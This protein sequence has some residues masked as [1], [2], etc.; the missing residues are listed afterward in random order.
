MFPWSS[1]FIIP[2]CLL[3]LTKRWETICVDWLPLLVLSCETIVLVLG[4]INIIFLVEGIRRSRNKTT[5]LQTIRDTDLPTVLIIV[6]TCGE[7][8]IVLKRT[9]DALLNLDYPEEKLTVVITDDCNDDDLELQVLEYAKIHYKRR[10]F[11]KGHAKAGN[12]NDTLFAIENKD[13]KYKGEL[14]LIL[15]CDMAP[16]P[17]MLKTLVSYLYKDGQLHYGFVQSPQHFENIQGFD[18]LGQHYYFFYQ[19]VLRA[20]NEFPLGVPCCGTNCLFRRD[21]L[22]SIGGFQTGSLTEDFKTSLELHSLGIETKYCSEILASGFAPLTLVDFFNQRC[23]WAM[24]GLQIIFS[25]SFRKMRYLPLTHIWIYGFAGLS[26]FY[27]LFFL[28]LMVC[29]LISF[30]I[31]TSFLFGLNNTRYLIYFTPYC[32]TY[33]LMLF[34][35]HLELSIIVLVTSV[36]ETLFMIPMLLRVLLVFILQSMGI[37]NISWKTTPKDNP[38]SYWCS[39]FCWLLPYILYIVSTIMCIIYFYDTKGWLINTIWSLFMCFQLAPI[40]LYQIQQIFMDI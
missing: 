10:G 26:P 40:V 17:K 27:S 32:L 14:V 24:G 36:Q 19:V 30:Y 7:G 34:Y 23:R 33:T 31:S 5:C 4:A 22:Q 20:W 37:S 13:Y 16:Y 35:L 12:V 2:P 21:I 11:I 39:T 6:P 15:D 29:P 18:F 8:I 9:M 25:S 1:L 38:Q 3:Y 28:I